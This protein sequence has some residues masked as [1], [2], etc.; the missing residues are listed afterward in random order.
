MNLEQEILREHSKEISA[1]MDRMLLEHAMFVN[2][3]A[4]GW[5]FVTIPKLTDNEHAVDITYWLADN[6]TEDEY[7]RDTRDFIFLR[8][9]DAVLFALRWA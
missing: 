3:I 6:V 2:R 4:D 5:H 7:Q 8:E 1:S 9:Q